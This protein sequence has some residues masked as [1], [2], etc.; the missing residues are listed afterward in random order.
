MVS[1]LRHPDVGG[2]ALPHPLLEE[3]TF[4]V[5]GIAADPDGLTPVRDMIQT[6]ALGDRSVSVSALKR[7]NL[8]FARNEG[9]LWMNT[10]QELRDLGLIVNTSCL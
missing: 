7:V 6:R 4:N 2:C 8:L 9:N 3:I 1:R 10:I 5:E